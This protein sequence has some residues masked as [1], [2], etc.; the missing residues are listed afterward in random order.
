MEK[1]KTFKITSKSIWE[2]SNLGRI[3]KNGNIYIP[4]VKGGRGTDNYSCISLNSPH[5]GYI[6]RIVASEFLDNPENKRTVNH[7]DGNKFNNNV[8]NLEWATYK[9]NIKHA[10]DTGLMQRDPNIEETRKRIVELKDGGMGP[11]AIGKLIG[12]SKQHVCMHYKRS[13]NKNN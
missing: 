12:I 13:K 3:K 2:V 1:W 9:E 7:K 8:N 5:S 6:H 10:F 4:H 11:T